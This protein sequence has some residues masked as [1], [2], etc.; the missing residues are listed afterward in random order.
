M[1]LWITY[2]FVSD[3]IEKYLYVKDQIEKKNLCKTILKNFL[4][5]RNQDEILVQ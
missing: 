5:G 4:F 1:T 3:Q 2:L